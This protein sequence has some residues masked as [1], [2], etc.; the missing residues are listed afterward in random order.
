MRTAVS[1]CSRGSSYIPLTA[2]S[3]FDRF[4]FAMLSVATKRFRCDS[5]FVGSW[6]SRYWKCYSRYYPLLRWIWKWWW[7]LV[8]RGLNCSWCVSTSGLHQ[9]IFDPSS[10]LSR[11][12]SEIFSIF[13]GR[14]ALFWMPSSCSENWRSPGFHWKLWANWCCSVLLSTFQQFHAFLRIDWEIRHQW[15]I[16]VHEWKP[17]HWWHY[18]NC[19]HIYSNKSNSD[20]YFHE[21]Y[22]DGLLISV[23]Y[24]SLIHEI[25]FQLIIPNSIVAPSH[26]SSNWMNSIKYCLCS[27]YCSRSR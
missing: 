20:W 13:C 21:N 18:P 23:S 2:L 26:S 25:S 10:S 24:C 3:L 7:K 22:C 14:W 5:S 1:C 4:Q 9:F 6:P 19:E 11:S 15:S 17:S 27:C 16:R 8:R 12:E